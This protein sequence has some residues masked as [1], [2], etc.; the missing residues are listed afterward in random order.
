MTLITKLQTEVI[1]IP[2]R[3]K[4]T[5]SYGTVSDAVNVIIKV[6]TDEEIVGIGEAWSSP[7]SGEPAEEMKL[8]IDRYLSQ[9]VIG[10]NPFDVVRIIE[11]MDAS[12]VGH[13]FA[14]SAIDMALW[15]IMGKSL[16]VPVYKLLGGRY[17]EGIP[18]MGFLTRG[19]AEEMQELAKREI[20]KGYDSVKMKIG[21]DAKKDFQLFRAVRAV[22]GERATIQVD[23]NQGYNLDVAIR[24]LTDMER[25]GGLGIV[26]QPVRRDDL[27]GM[28]AVAKVL[29]APVMADE[30]V[31]SI[32]D[33]INVVKRKA[34]E[35]LLIKLG[36]QGG[37][38]NSKRIA[39]IMEAAGIPLSVACYADITAAAA[40]HFA[41][42]T[43]SVIY[44]APL[45][46]LGDTILSR[47]LEVEKLTLKIPDNPG[48]GVE[49][50]ESK[51]S[52][53]RIQ[54]E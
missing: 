10:Q 4:L 50:D 42:S 36:K 5:T 31:F 13:P 47:P 17:N 16:N 14:K 9:A 43:K 11:R 2:R 30:S 48:L 54:V 52:K 53:Y 12:L 19:T 27:E 22:I 29:D 28:S 6:L 24:V 41:I 38:Y 51:I 49:I 40:I 34:A 46:D 33:A 32:Y 3:A 25:H 26:E 21:M 20:N 15:D 45:T 39:A 7:I 8:V 1:K 18:L 35:V 37:L 44:P 23:A